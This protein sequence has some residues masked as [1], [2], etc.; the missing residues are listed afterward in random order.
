MVEA[1]EHLQN[2]HGRF[3]CRYALA[4]IMTAQRWLGEA[5]RDARYIPEVG[6]SFVKDV[7]AK[8]NELGALRSEFEKRCMKR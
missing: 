1:R 5:M 4:A 2:P 6:G 7:R 8:L 3:N